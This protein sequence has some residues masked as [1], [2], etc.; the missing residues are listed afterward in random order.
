MSG[1]AIYIDG[2]KMPNLLMSVQDGLMPFG[3]FVF[4]WAPNLLPG[5]HEAKFQLTKDSGEI[6]EYIWRFI[7]TEK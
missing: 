2:I 6:I 5:L 4:N 3:P 1:M 7:V